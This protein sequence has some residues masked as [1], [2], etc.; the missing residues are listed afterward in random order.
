ML[1]GLAIKGELGDTVSCRP[2][3]SEIPFF[4]LLM[5]ASCR[6]GE[7][8][9]TLGLSLT[10]PMARQQLPLIVMACLSEIDRRW[11]AF[12]LARPTQVSIL[13]LLGQ[14]RHETPSLH[15]HQLAQ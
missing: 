15:N 9:S 13:R 14:Y 4:R 11:V 2:A 10:D 5:A 7:T 6:T 3:L 8:Y 1:V 12:M